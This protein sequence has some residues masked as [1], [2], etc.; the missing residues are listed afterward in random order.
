LAETTPSD[1]RIW[2]SHL[3]AQIALAPIA[4]ALIELPEGHYP[5][6]IG[7]F[8]VGIVVA[9]V[10]GRRMKDEEA[11]TQAKEATTQASRRSYRSL[12]SV[13]AVIVTWVL[14]ALDLGPSFVDRVET[15]LSSLVTSGTASPQ[16]S[17]APTVLSQQF[18]TNLHSDFLRIPRPCVLKIV[19]PPKLESARDQLV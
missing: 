1:E 18:L 7:Y 8:A 14:F 4:A 10:V 3:G 13:V 6:V 2:W 15:V 17:S 5:Y 12:L 19:A 9:L 16:V 11:T